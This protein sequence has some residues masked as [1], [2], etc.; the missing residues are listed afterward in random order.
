MSRYSAKRA[1]YLRMFEV[2][3]LRRLQCVSAL[4]YKTTYLPTSSTTLTRLSFCRWC[5]PVCVN[6]FKC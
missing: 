4:E 6:L 2:T 3:S 5:A 1:M